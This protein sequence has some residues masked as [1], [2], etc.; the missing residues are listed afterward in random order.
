MAEPIFLFAPGAGAPSSHSW[1]KHWFRLLGKIGRVR[2]F[3]YP[4]M[5]QKRTRPDRLPVLI[6]AHRAL[7]VSVQK[8]Q[9]GPIVLIGKSM[10]SRI[11]CHVALEETV[12]AVVCLG[13]PL[14]GAGD[15]AKMRDEVLLKLKTPILFV[16]GTRD[17]FCPLDLLESVRS[18]MVS[19]NRL[20]IVADGD[21]SLAVAKRA[22]KATGESQS[23]TDVRV[24]ERIEAFVANPKRR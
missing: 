21:H 10:G 1:M 9:R 24:L 2:T 5:I 18:R 6:A 7:L 23:D 17:P 4:Y 8:S 3:D 11:G 12:H 22:L 16:Q 14:C 13:Y 19:V 15:R 20:E